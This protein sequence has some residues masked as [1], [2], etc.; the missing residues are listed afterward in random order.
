MQN[1]YAA[2][3]DRTPEPHQTTA[4]WLAMIVFAVIAALG[5]LVAI[6]M[7]GI[8]LGIAGNLKPPEDLDKLT[9]GQQSVVVDRTG[10]VQLATFGEIPRQVV[11]FKE[12]P[13]ALVDATTAVE[14]R[15]F[16]TNS[17]FDPAAIIAAGVDALR[18]NPRG[19]STITQQ[20]V[21]QRLLDEDLV[22]DPKRTFERKLEEIIQSIRLTKR[23]GEGD[24]G[25]QQLMA[26]YL[27][28][29][30]YG[31]NSYGVAVAAQSYFGKPLNKLTLAE[32][33]ILAAI[34]QS[35]ARYDL[36]RNA[37]KVGK[38]LVVP[39]DS[40]IVIR[41]NFILGVMEAG[42]APLTAG[43][44]TQ[45]DYEKAKAEPVKLASQAEPHWAAPHFIWA[46]RDELTRRVCGANAATCDAIE[47]GGFRITSTLDA[48]LQRIGEKWVAAA[49][50]IP[51]AK[52]SD[53]E[54]KL[55][56]K[57]G[58]KTVQPWMRNLQ[59]KDVNNGALVAIDYQTGQIV[60]YVG[61]ADYYAGKGTKKFQPKFDVAGDGW[62]Q[63]GS[64]F[65][66]FNYLTGIDDGSLTAATMLMDVGTDFGGGYTPTDADN[67]E[68]GPVRVRNAL[69]F[70][71]N[72][73]AVKAMGI[74]GI[75]HVFDRAQDFGLRFRVKQTPAGLAFALGVQEVHPI[76]MVTGYGTIANGGKYVE[77]TTLLDVKNPD[78]SKTKLAPLSEPKQVAKPQ[79]AAIITD[80]LSGNTDPKIN[81]FWGKFEITN[82]G[83]RRPATLKTGTNNDAKDL[84]A[85]GYIAPPD[86]AGRKDGELAIA[87]GVWNGNSDNTEVSTPAHPVFSI[88]VSTFVWQ[89]FMREATRHWK[90]N[91]FKRPGGLE[92]AQVDPWV[93]LI[94]GSRRAVTEIFLPGKVPT[95][96]ASVN[97]GV[98][99]EGIIRDGPEANH[100]NWLAADRDWI[101]RAQRG[102]G[103]RGGP[104]G[105]R[106]AYFY[107][108]L[109][110]P[111]GHS[112]GPLLGGGSCQTPVPSFS[113]IPQPTPD[114]SGVVPPIVIP[115]PSGSEVVPQ[116][117]PTPP[118]TPPP[119]VEPSIPT[120]PPKT[121]P[122][123]PS[124]APSPP[125]SVN[126]DASVAIEAASA[127]P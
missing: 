72:I 116:P 9:F 68:R 103:V 20:L 14:D 21:R 61:S 83:Q 38:D 44:Y 56:K 16:W 123:K 43:K 7:L 55:L 81:P 76:D 12:I 80:I 105:T 24:Q 114:A 70:S 59:S 71:L 4:G 100:D 33:A 118:P 73:P 85:Y 49:A 60:A 82:D 88:D 26:A 84:N 17:G 18:G 36:V 28:Q 69:Q 1:S 111:Y 77:H 8:F 107:N 96:R 10:K 50:L 51:K 39:A 110:M 120:E 34:P 115:S 42:N 112:W 109:Y 62:R 86:E 23:F 30:F 63:P 5:A 66:P 67:L 3:Y 35:P 13:P 64:A 99:G 101:R 98:C 125:P 31:N 2:R 52:D 40:D 46:L 122:G 37:E 121:P 48:R 117:C 89:G 102:P 108:A 65:K 79:A 54:A 57:Y 78:G 58:F 104:D 94:S 6:A 93:G 126:A 92:E 25:K 32:A 91:D 106:T 113:C 11:E 19:A 41:R 127:G 124:E 53:E 90:I 29:N 87:V 45:A 15:T 47:Q 119:S 74:N 97:G 75:D 95:Q 27:N 22:R